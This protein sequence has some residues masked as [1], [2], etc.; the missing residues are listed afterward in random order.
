MPHPVVED[1]TT[2]VRD[3]EAMHQREKRLVG[4]DSRTV[5]VK[6]KHRTSERRALR[7]WQRA[8]SSGCCALFDL[9]AMSVIVR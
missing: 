6:Y 7:L 3:R 1:W 2:P 8:M 9:N 5:G 4:V